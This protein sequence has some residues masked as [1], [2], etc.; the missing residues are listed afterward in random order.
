M[1]AFSTALCDSPEDRPE[2]LFNDMFIGGRFINN[3]VLLA[4]VAERIGSETRFLEDLGVPFQ[5]QHGKLARRQAAGVSWPRA[6]FTR[7]MLGVDAG[8]ILLERL[9]A[10][11]SPDVHV[12]KNA[13]LLDLDIRDGS[14]AG[15]LSYLPREDAWLH[16]LAPAVVIATGGIG[17]LYERTT[18]FG[19][20]Q[21]IGYALALEAGVPCVDMEFVSFEPTVAVAPAKIAGKE[22]PTM[23]FSDGA[24][25]LNGQGEEFIQT[26]PPPSKDI[27]CRA[28][29]REVREGRGTPHGAIYYDLRQMSHGAVFSYAHMRQV[30]KAL[31][32]PPEK[33][34]IEV[35]PA[36]HFMMG[37]IQTNESAATVIKGL[38]AAGEA[39]GGVHGAHRL[40]TCGGTEAIA[41]GA[42][43]GES[44]AHHAQ[45]KWAR[46]VPCPLEAKPQL[47]PSADDLAD[48][49]IITRI[50]NSLEGGCGV[51]RVAQGLKNSLAA[52]NSIRDHLMA[53]GRTKTYV[54]RAVLVALAVAM[55]ASI[56]TESRGDHFRID[57]PYRDDRRWFGNLFAALTDD[58][59]NVVVQALKSLART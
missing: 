24:R 53:D 25:L 17:Q 16:I 11:G 18:N 56:R 20:S 12:M 52:L 8:K 44:A 57:Y 41:M 48:N 6:V 2:A 33:A 32:L 46:P 10:A 5:Q 3:P 29:L 13:L 38:F 7:D 14:V 9:Q 4:A 34:R 37:G 1:A 27:M 45:G 51:L 35:A 31:D 39:A 15:G 26:K 54:G 42:I 30:L 50:R 55:S 23:A 59:T 22:L 36:Q 19:G 58:R 21:A 49:G 40:A 47:L 28:M 43:A